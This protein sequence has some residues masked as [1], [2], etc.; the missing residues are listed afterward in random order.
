[1]AFLQFSKTYF[2]TT[3]PEDCVKLI[4]LRV[5]QAAWTRSSSVAFSNEI[6]FILLSTQYI[7]WSAWFRCSNKWNQRKKVISLIRCK[8][9]NALPRCVNCDYFAMSYVGE[10]SAVTRSLVHH[11][12]T[13]AVHSQIKWAND[14][15]IRM[16]I[17]EIAYKNFKRKRK[18]T[19]FLNFELEIWSWQ[20][21]KFYLCSRL[22]SVERSWQIFPWG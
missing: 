4:Y 11:S 19:H 3:T 7:V 20:L 5:P 14:G 1:M 10:G 13:L 9:G 17:T 21:Y 2:N 8:P 22:S 12:A 18:R 6:N 16:Q 15:L